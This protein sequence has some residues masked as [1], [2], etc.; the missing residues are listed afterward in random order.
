MSWPGRVTCFVLG[1]DALAAPLLTTSLTHPI[2]G[3]AI[4]CYDFTI[5]NERF[6]SFPPR[7]SN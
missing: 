4:G 6:E 5:G 7:L 1:D 3:V 2:S